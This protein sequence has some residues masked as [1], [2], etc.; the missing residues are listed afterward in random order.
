MVFVLLIRVLVVIHK[1]TKLK[2]KQ[3]QNDVRLWRYGSS[4]ITFC[5]TQREVILKIEGF[6][7]QFRSFTMQF[8]KVLV[9]FSSFDVV[10]NGKKL[11]N[12][13]Q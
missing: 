8:L 1:H 2:Q 4:K 11:F 9:V 3:C 13:V 12:K 10:D 7:L 5:F 6:G